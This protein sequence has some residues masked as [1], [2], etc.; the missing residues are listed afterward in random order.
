ALS[1]FHESRSEEDFFLRVLFCPVPVARAHAY[2]FF[3]RRGEIQKVYE[4]LIRKGADRRS[5]LGMLDIWFRLID[6]STSEQ[7]RVHGEIAAEIFLQVHA[8]LPTK[9]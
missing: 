1:E 7:L 2:G 3:K 5:S 8:V 6:D 4:Y 9:S